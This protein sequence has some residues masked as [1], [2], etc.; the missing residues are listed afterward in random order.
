M[1]VRKWVTEVR[2]VYIQVV[3]KFEE[4]DIY[5][6]IGYDRF[7]KHSVC[8]KAQAVLQSTRVAAKHMGCCK[9]VERTCHLNL[10]A[11]G[12]RAK[13]CCSPTLRHSNTGVFAWKM[14]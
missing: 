9:A 1:R 13:P 4:Y 10:C 8:C 6:Y 12:G 7:M 14:T 3:H 11:F 5:I 2:H